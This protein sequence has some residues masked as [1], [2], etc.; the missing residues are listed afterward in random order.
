MLIQLKI[1]CKLLNDTILNDTILL[2]C[3]NMKILYKINFIFLIYY[4]V[5]TLNLNLFYDIKLSKN[6]QKF[7]KIVEH[8]CFFQFQQLGNFLHSKY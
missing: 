8:P 3:K 5:I 4:Y 6:N 7:S 2:S 1:N